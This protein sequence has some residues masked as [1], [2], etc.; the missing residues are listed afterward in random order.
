[1][2]DINTHRSLLLQILKEVYSN[3]TLG[4][5]L[6]FKGGTASYLFYDL[7]RFSVD[8]DFDL[9]EESK[10]GYIFERIGEIV[11]GFGKLKE[12]FNKRFTLFFVISYSEK[13]QNIKI[14]INK[15]PFGSNY[16]LKNYLGI[17]MLVM[18]KEDMF[19][20]KLVALDERKKIA[21]RDIFDI[22]F[23]LKNNWDIN[24]ELIKKRTGLKLNDYIKKCISLIETVNERYIL[25]GMG[26]LLDEKLKIWTRENLK[27]DVLFLLKLKLKEL[28]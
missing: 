15:R 21:N 11:T 6:G 1:M 4:P 17:S 22:W 8:L 13:H 27:K 7:N 19:A 20:H 28:K 16:E 14:E 23:Y 10:E 25:Q 18:V 24:E 5:V 12:K 2:L 9:L 26:E 3:T